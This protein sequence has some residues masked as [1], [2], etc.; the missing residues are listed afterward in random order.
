MYEAAIPLTKVM[1]NAFHNSFDSAANRLFSLSGVIEAIGKGIYAPEIEHVRQV[2]HRQGKSAY[3]RAKAQLPA[4]T[5][6]GTFWPTR[7][8]A[9]LR[10][11][12]GI[13]HGDL[14]DL[15]DVEATKQVLASDQRTAYAFVSPSGIGLKVGVHIAVVADDTAYKHAWQTVA[16]EYARLYGVPWDRSGKDISRLCFVSHD[17]DPYMN[18]NAEVFDVPPPP[19]PP[20]LDNSTPAPWLYAKPARLSQSARG[21][22]PRA[23]VDRA[24]R[25]ATRMIQ[26]AELGSRHH[27]RLK[28]ARLLGGYIGAGLLTEREA[29]DTLAHALEEHTEDLNAALKT[30]RDGI[31]YGRAAPFSLPTLEADWQRWIDTHQPTTPKT[32]HP[33]AEHDPWEGQRTLPLKPYQ[34]LRLGRMVRRG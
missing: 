14:D 3:D 10:Q 5:F 24:I 12:S 33:P 25:T 9:N 28:A 30:I 27:T 31:G 11:H 32:P 6:C 17:P 16:T 7:G 23:D 2:L 4:Y 29:Y 34:G 8:I 20:T 1:I 18:F 13:A 21:Y 15:P 26:T 19:P 22:D